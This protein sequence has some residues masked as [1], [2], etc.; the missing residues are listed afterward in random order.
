[1]KAYEL[2]NRDNF[3]AYV[4]ELQEYAEGSWVEYSDGNYGVVVSVVEGPVEW[5]T[6]EEETEEVGE[7]GQYVYVVARQTGGSK[8]F[9][10]E[11]INGAERSD[12]ID[13]EEVPEE[14]EEDV[15]DAE[16]SAIYEKVDDPNS[17]EELINVPGVD[18]PG[19]GFDS[20]PDS[21]EDADE[22]ARL[23]ALD[24]WSSMGGTFTG[25]MS[26]IG[27]RRICAAFKDEMLGT[28]RWRN[29]F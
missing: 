4:A 26:E 28:E 12:V 16:M 2:L 21:W 3:T 29:R 19:L 20:W 11:E 24:A 23:I 27:S 25:C 15:D 5:P 7:D 10:A 8:P 14:P 22:P 13:T 9:T 17:Y 18:D 1:M 6:G